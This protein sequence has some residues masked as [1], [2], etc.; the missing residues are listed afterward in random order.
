[1]MNKK[2]KGLCFHCDEKFSP[3]HKCKDRTLQVLTVCDNEDNEYKMN[4]R[5][6]IS[7]E[8]H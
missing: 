1:M 5:E 3:R 6:E 7:E 8:E 4:V 2:A